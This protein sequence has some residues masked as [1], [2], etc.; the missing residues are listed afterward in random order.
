MNAMTTTV[1]HLVSRLT[2]EQKAAQLSAF[3]VTDL[4]DRTAAEQRAEI[5]IDI[6]RLAA[7]R[8]HG[9]GHLSLAWFLGHDAEAC[10]AAWTRCR[11]RYARPRRSASGRWRTCA[12]AHGAHG[13]APLR[14]GHRPR[15]AGPV[16]AP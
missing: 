14:P 6:D 4:I 3:A 12:G 13:A 10:A 1:A 16:R 2:L 5:S 7:L 8:P 9:T 15:A 11:P